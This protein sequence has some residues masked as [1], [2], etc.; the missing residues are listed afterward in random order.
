MLAKLRRYPPYFVNSIASKPPPG[1]NMNRL[2]WG[3]LRLDTSRN[4]A[5]APWGRRIA[6]WLNSEP[7]QSEAIPDG[8][9]SHQGQRQELA[10]P[11]VHLVRT[12]HVHVDSRQGRPALRA[13]RA[14]CKR[15]TI[16]CPHGPRNAP[17]GLAA[18]EA[19]RDPGPAR[20]QPRCHSRI[21]APSAPPQNEARPGVRGRRAVQA[22]RFAND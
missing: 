2:A 13:Y 11:E 18:P 21:R 10:P 22:I 4:D 3:R 7:C 5:S 16:G 6:I 14:R 9:G 20:R 15:R 19:P 12:R 1:V 8:H 17:C